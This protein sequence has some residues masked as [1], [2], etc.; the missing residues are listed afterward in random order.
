MKFLNKK[1]KTQ[2]LAAVI[3]LTAATS[4]Q[5][6]LNINTDPN[7]FTDVPLRTILP[8]AQ[9]NLA[10]TLGGDASRYTGSIMQYY[11]GH[12][13]QPLEYAQFTFNASTTDTY[14]SNMYTSVL[15]Q[16]K[17][18]IGKADVSGDKIYTGIAQITMA[19]TFS[20]LTDMY[21]DIPYAE[22]L[23]STENVSPAYDRQDTIYPALI[24]M[25]DQG[26]ANVKSGQGTKP[27]TDDRVYAG[28]V[29][30][31]EKFA[32]SL[33]LRLYN[34]QSKVQPNAAAD[35]LATNPALITTSADNAQVV[36]GSNASNSNPIYQFDVLSGRKDQAV[37]STIVNRMKAL[38]DPRIP[39]YFQGIVNGANKGQYVGNGPGVNDDDSGETKYSRVGSFYASATS[40]VVFLSA[41]EVQFII[42]E[43]QFRKGNQAAAATAYDAAVKNDF[44]AL[45]VTGAEAYLT[46]AGVKY[47]N[48]L[49]RIMEQKWITMYQA[50]YESW[51][52]W[53]RTAIPMLTVPT[54]NY[55]GGVIPRRL[56]YPQLELNLN[57]AS[58]E[59]GPGFLSPVE[60]MKS[61]VW[62][63]K[64]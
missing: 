39:V 12:R 30:K 5:D 9:V 37:A 8:A 32:N 59:A 47:D 36:F 15:T 25:L 34:H 13:G 49:N 63:D 40:P 10:Y 28:D 1:Y 56:P 24:A 29:T 23:L 26:I 64:Q 16:M 11:G 52:D 17:A 18:V 51:V 44:T 20:I 35:F 19:H 42:A 48:T 53:R 22:A 55:S 45:G 31:W 58:L 21:G 6:S 46:T 50:P 60:T 27:G 7:S 41:A 43:A 14:W 2:L 4:C 38:A 3:L 54:V 33:K 61:R 62:W 57:R